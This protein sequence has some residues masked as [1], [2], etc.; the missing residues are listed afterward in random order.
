[1]KTRILFASF[2]LSSSL[3]IN[4]QVPKWKD[5]AYSNVSPQQKLDIYLPVKGKGPFPVIVAIHGGGWRTGDKADGQVKAMLTG[6]NRG[7]AVVSINYRLSDEAHGLELLHDVK[8]AIRW[9]RANATIYHLKTDKI[10]VWGNSAGG[11]LS[12]LAGTTGDVL[13]IDDLTLGNPT[14][15]SRVQA[16]VDWYGPIN[17]LTMDYQY[18][19]L[20]QNGAKHNTDQSAESKM[21]DKKITQAVEEV[22]AV[23]PTTYISVDDP[24]FFIEHGTRDMIVPYLQSTVFADSIYKVLGPDKVQL[25]LLEGAAHDDP[26][27]KNPNNLN[28]VFAFLDKYIKN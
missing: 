18:N 25:R 26:E 11:H 5:L 7:Y 17:F 2:F 12:T 8:A 20:D 15:S 21:I 22:K 10:A 27:F 1:M 13:R 16:V 4:A 3:M 14:F 19:I 9:I 24:P 28:L 23:N 6:L